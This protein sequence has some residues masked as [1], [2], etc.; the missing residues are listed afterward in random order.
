LKV[1]VIAIKIFYLC[2]VF[3]PN[4]YD[5]AKIKGSVVINA[6]QCKGCGLCVAEC[7]FG[8]LALSQEVNSKGYTYAAMRQADACTGCASC[9]QVCPDAVITVYRAKVAA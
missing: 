8:V 6:E 1:S 7:P 5:M 4:N 9:A 2:P 3:H